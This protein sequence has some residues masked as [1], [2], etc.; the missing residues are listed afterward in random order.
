M[1]EMAYEI[2]LFTRGEGA[3]KTTQDLFSRADVFLQN[4]VV[5]YAIVKEFLYQIPNGY[6]KNELTQLIEQLPLNF[7]QLK[8]KLKQTTI[9]KTATFNKV[10]KI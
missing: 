5:L 10:Y 6:L 3:L 8:S 9:G 2:H 1:S 4:G 7:K